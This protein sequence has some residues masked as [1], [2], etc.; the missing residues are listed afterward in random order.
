MI[1]ATRRAGVNLH[2]TALGTDGF[3]R[4]DT[5]AQ[6]RKFFEVDR[7]YIA[8]AA[9]EALYRWRTQTH[10]RR[11]SRE[12]SRSNRPCVNLI[13]LNEEL[14]GIEPVVVRITN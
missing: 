12:R 8:H 11:Q 3:G 13:E 7:N 2:Y 10:R 9:F 5:R 4:S 1:D 14:I 6:L